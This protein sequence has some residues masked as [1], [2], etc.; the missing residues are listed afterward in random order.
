MGAYRVKAPK[1]RYG[2]RLITI[3]AGVV[4]TLRA[5]RLRQAEI[6]LALGLGRPAP[7]DLV[8]AKEDGSPLSPDKLSQQWRR[9]AD[10]LGLPPVTFHA[11][12]HTHASALIAAAL[13]ILTISRRLGHGSPGITLGIYAHKFK[14]TDSAAAQAI[15]AAMR[16]G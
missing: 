11:F 9:T 7:D 16:N 12:R 15:D 5:H 13:D 10:T 3:L 6:R 1:S 8:F 14:K 4:E 2:R